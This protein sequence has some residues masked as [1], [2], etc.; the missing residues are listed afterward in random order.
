MLYELFLIT[1]G[2]YVGQEYPILPPV[3]ILISNLM[4][5]YLGNNNNRKETGKKD[6][7]GNDQNYNFNLKELWKSIKDE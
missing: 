7:Q 2:I 5:T 1:F 4:A 3:K 6:D